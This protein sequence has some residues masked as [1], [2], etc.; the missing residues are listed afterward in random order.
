MLI[1]FIF[2]SLAS[3]SHLVSLAIVPINVVVKPVG[4]RANIFHPHLHHRKLA[5][6]PKVYKNPFDF[7]PGRFI[8]T[9]DGAAEPDPREVCFGFGRRCAQFIL[10][11]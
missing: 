3:C 11:G 7:N 5:H 10:S 9:E 6:D 4:E 8:A 2:T 1:E